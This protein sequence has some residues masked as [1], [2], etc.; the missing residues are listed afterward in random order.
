MWDRT[1]ISAKMKKVK[2]IFSKMKKVKSKELC[3][4]FIDGFQDMEKDD[5]NFTAYFTTFR[6]NVKSWMKRVSRSYYVTRAG[7]WHA[8]QTQLPC[9]MVRAAYPPTDK[10]RSSDMV[11]LDRDSRMYNLLGATNRDCHLPNC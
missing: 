5:K 2:H 7:G 9:D 4:L 1:L 6:C 11:L 8:T 10:N 3:F